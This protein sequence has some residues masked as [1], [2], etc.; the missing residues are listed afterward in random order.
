MSEISIL[1]LTKNEERNIG[2]CLRALFSQKCAEPFEVILVDSGS[3]DCTLEIARS[4]PVRIEQIPS[5]AFHHAC[6]RNFAAGLANGQFLVYLAADALPASNTWLGALI[7]NFADPS[8]GAVYG[9]H[10]PRPGSTLERQD[11]LD[12]VYGDARLVKDASSRQKLGYR[13][14]HLST[15]NAAIRRDVWQAT[16]FPEDLKVFEDLGIAKRILD[17]GWMIV[18]EP[19]ACVYHSHQHTT[20]GLFKRYFD[21]GVT[22]KRLDMW[23]DQARSSMLQDFW[24]LL[25]KKVTRFD[26]NGASRLVGASIRQD[27]AKSA[28]IFLGLNEHYLPLALKRRSSAFRLFD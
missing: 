9:R 10:L 17:S 16:R 5:E 15:V 23:N 8:V 13:Y 14:Y 12:A 2:A 1:L 7:A 4:Y 11:A 3:T 27:L 20:V 22:L 25:K 19:G 24:G 6:T 26:G 28:G 18:Y 21:I